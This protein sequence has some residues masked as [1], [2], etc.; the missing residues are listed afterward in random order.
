MGRTAIRDY[1]R[2]LQRSPHNAR[3][4]LISTVFRAASTG[5]WSLLL[6]LYLDSMGF[7]VAF[8]GLTNTLFSSFSVVCS[9]PAGLIGNPPRRIRRQLE[10]PDLIR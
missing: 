5:I 8:I 7:G 9:V 3:L 4:Y 1:W 6:N 2:R 10:G